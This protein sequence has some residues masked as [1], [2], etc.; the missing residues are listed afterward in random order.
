MARRCRCQDY[1][2]REN[3]DLA[4]SPE[5][6]GVSSSARFERPYHPCGFRPS[7]CTSPRRS[8]DSSLVYIAPPLGVLKSGPP[9]AV[10][11]LGGAL[12]DV[13]ALL[14]R[15]Q[16]FVT[17]EKCSQFREENNEITDTSEQCSPFSR[18]QRLFFSVTP[19]PA[20]VPSHSNDEKG[21]SS[22]R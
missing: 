17:V 19:A 13:Q 18:T 3:A 15:V 5:Q 12:H 16:C 4:W 8:T 10:R 22:V 6:T 7:L 2:A 14:S 11:S 9:M 21:G 1:L 20:R